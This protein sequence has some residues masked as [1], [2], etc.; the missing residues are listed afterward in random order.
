M[1]LFKK[2]NLKDQKNII[3]LNQPEGFSSFIKEIDP[4]RILKTNLRGVKE[5][6]FIICFCTKERELHTL[7][8]KIGPKFKGDVIFWLAYPKKSS[9]KYK[10]DFNRDSE[11]EMM[12][13]YHLEGVR[14][15]AIDN[16]WSALRFRNVA[17]IKTM[18]R[19]FKALS[20]K[21]KIKAGQKR[22]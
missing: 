16:D 15:V 11:W 8:D 22:G 17:Y 9:K 19:K 21:G 4:D 14:M 3:V 12:G 2:L 1:S 6:E 20:E 5:I 10:A 7:M 18:K 13:K